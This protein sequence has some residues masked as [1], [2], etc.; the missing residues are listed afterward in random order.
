MAHKAHGVNEL[1][2]MFLKFFETKNHL[3]LPSFSLIPQN[4]KSLLLINSGMAPMKPYFTGE[5]EPPRRRVCTCQKCIRTG[6]IENI[7]KT[8]RH[9]TYFEMLGNFSF[10]DYFKNES[11]QWSWEFLTSPEWVGLEPE[12]MYPTVYENDDEAWDIWTK[13]IGV[14]EDHMTRLGKKD[15]F[16]EH[17]AG[18]CGPCSEIHYDRGEEFGCGKPGCRPGCDCDRFME[19]WNNVFSQFNNDG[20]GNYTELAQKNIDT[21]MGLE[22]LACVCQNVNSLFD[23][24]TVMNITNHVTRL[25]GASYGQSYKTDVSLR[26]ITDHI[27]ASTF[28]I[29]DGVLP[30]NEGRG[31]VLR[32]L[33]RRAARHGKL[34]GVN[35][36]FLFEVVETVVKEN[37]IHYTYLRE[38]AEYITRIV[39]IE[40]ENFARTID[41]GMAIFNEKMAAHKAE[42]KAVFSGEDAFLLSDTYGFPVDLTVEMVEDE[43]MTLDMDK[44]YACR[45]EQRVRAREARKALGDLAWA[46]I[47]LGLDNTPTAF[48]GYSEMNCEAKVLAVCVGDE[49][50]GTIAGGENGIIVLDKTP[51]YAEMG[52]Q[53]AD[54]GVIL[55]GDSRFIVKNVLKDKGGKYLHHGTMASGSIKVDDVVLASIDVERRKAIMRAHSATHLLQKALT[56]V[57]GDHVHQAGSLVEP[58]HLRFDF[59]HYS[60]MTA[61]EIAKV[62]EIVQAAVL[63]GYGIETREMGIEE[64]KK[65]GA[66]ALFSE[67]YGDTV[68][69]V[70]MGGWS[71]ELCGGTHLDNTAK[72]GPFRIESEASVASGVRRIEAITGKETLAEMSRTR[73]RIYD[74]CAVL[75]TKPAELAT[76]LETQVEE[77]KALK[78]AV[79]SYKA[80]ETAGEVER[81]LF[82]AHDVSGLH[83][84][85]ATVPNA[86]AG[87]LRQMGDTLRDKDENVV[88]VLATVSGEKITFLAVCGKQANAKGVRAGDLVKLVC[89]TCGGSGGGKPDSA[90]G[91]G[92][93]LLKLD[94]ALAQVDNFVASKLN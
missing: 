45:E 71:I 90:M 61:E 64:A 46:G 5:V 86:D 39:K 83:V 19:V 21:G 2:E 12:R 41:T 1:R 60:A 68:R 35:N 63:E 93:D 66:T 20:A 69:V 53:V 57:L 31:Y 75:K 3:R 89:T 87:K 40:E 33:L 59:T 10:G 67:K 55:V 8:A 52:G 37:E 22:R 7:G 81:F 84:L 78:K 13:V 54:H 48:V 82:G 77:I 44:F 42:G 30:S 85:T 14:P 27:R 65:L 18:P 94:D 47:D 76:K 72:V 62:D 4:D 38:R 73:K 6:D 34:L 79:E 92:K 36:P 80:K 25:S 49:V 32:R 50:S 9:G 24:D 28:M 15:N 91:G 23:V 56:S 51:F 43:G 74:A 17:G 26:V 88:A 58:D 70:N 11:L 29:A 16:W